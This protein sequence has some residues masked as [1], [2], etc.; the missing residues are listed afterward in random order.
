MF[1]KISCAILGIFL[2]TGNVYAQ[3]ESV[4]LRHT[5]QIVNSYCGISTALEKAQKDNQRIFVGIVD[6]HNI[7]YLTLNKEGFW[8]ISMA[9]MSGISCIYFVGQAGT[10]VIGTDEKKKKDTDFKENIGRRINGEYIYK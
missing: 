6:E 3:E 9:N 5:P 2:L 7:L 8:T 4:A 1:T 10:L